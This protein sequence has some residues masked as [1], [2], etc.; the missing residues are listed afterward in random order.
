MLAKDALTRAKRTIDAAEVL[1]EHAPE[2]ARA[3]AGAIRTESI[4]AF[5]RSDLSFGGVVTAPTKHLRAHL[6]EQ[7]DEG[8]WTQVFEAKE[9]IKEIEERCMSMARNAF[10]RWE[11]AMRWAS[12]QRMHHPESS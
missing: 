11:T 1:H 2:I 8:G 5:V 3:C 4:I 6:H 9:G 10:A 7:E 12:R